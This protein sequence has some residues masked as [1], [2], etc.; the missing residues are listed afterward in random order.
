MTPEES[1]TIDMLQKQYAYFKENL[2]IFLTCEQSK[3]M[4]NVYDTCQTS[5]L[6]NHYDTLIEDT[7]LTE[8]QTNLIINLNENNHQLKLSKLT[9]RHIAE[10]R[11]LEI[12]K[13][14]VEDLKS[15]TQIATKDVLTGKINLVHAE[16]QKELEII[17][18]LEKKELSILAA[19]EKK[20]KEIIK[21]R[22]R[23]ESKY[24]K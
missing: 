17:A 4:C 7:N 8:K 21:S 9:S 19:Q 1:E 13:Q 14:N 2:N 22:I 18:A 12:I 16:K 10:L 3:D 20:E 5:E 11:D 23:Y 6:R 24:K 15:K